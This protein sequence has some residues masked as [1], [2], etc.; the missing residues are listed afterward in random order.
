MN[1]G[2]SIEIAMR[3]ERRGQKYYFAIQIL[4]KRQVVRCHVPAN[5]AVEIDRSRSTRFTN[6]L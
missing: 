4:I 6:V 1:M 2:K 3:S 5:R